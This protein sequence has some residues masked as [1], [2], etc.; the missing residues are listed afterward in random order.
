LAATSS[1]RVVCCWR[2]SIP[3][4]VGGGSALSC[5][6]AWFRWVSSVLLVIDCST[7][8]ANNGPNAAQ[9]AI[10]VLTPTSTTVCSRRCRSDWRR[11]TSPPS[12]LTG[13]PDFVPQATYVRHG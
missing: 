2:G 10:S 12:S 11:Y 13:P 8:R 5:S 9:P 6:E 1:G 3:I 7:A 4:S